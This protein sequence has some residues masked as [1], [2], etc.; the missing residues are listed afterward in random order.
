[1]VQIEGRSP[2]SREALAVLAG[3]NAVAVETWAGWEV[4]QY[5]TAELVGGD[6][7]QLSG[8]LRGQGGG[9]LEAEAGA[10]VGADVVFL[11]GS[12]VALGAM[13]EEY[14]LPLVWR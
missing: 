10:L 11:D 3:A 7:W 13:R 14:G 8:L 4:I 5:R 6:V 12:L 2:E 9:E 1:M